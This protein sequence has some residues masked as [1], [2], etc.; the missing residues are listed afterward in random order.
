VLRPPTPTGDPAERLT[1]GRAQAV[2]RFP[3]GTLAR[4]EVT[5][6]VIRPAAAKAGTVVV[7]ELAYTV[8]LPDPKKA[9]PMVLQRQ[10]MNGADAFPLSRKTVQRPQGSHLSTL[11]VTLPAD[12]PAGPYILVTTVS[13]AGLI[14]SIESVLTVR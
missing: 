9:V 11:R 5:A 8:L 6:S 10:L 7:A 2:K 12:L 4:L 13:G 14:R 3:V 1:A